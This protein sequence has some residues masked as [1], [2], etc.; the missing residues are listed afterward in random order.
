MIT[1]QAKA[2]LLDREK[3]HSLY[4][5]EDLTIKQIMSLL[6][7]SYDAVQRHLKMHSLTKIK[8]YSDD[9]IVSVYE[10]LKTVDAT[11]RR[12]G[13]P[14][15]YVK[16]LLLERGYDLSKKKKP[17]VP[18]ADKNLLCDLYLQKFYNIARI[19]EQLGENHEDV[20][21]SLDYYDIPKRKHGHGNIKEDALEKL[22][23]KKWLDYQYNHSKRSAISIANELGVY[24]T[25]PLKFLRLHGFNVRK[26]NFRSKEEDAILLALTE[27]GL[28]P[29]TN[30][31]LNGIEL[32]IYVPE[33]KLAIEVNGVYWHTEKHGRGKEYHL[34]K[35]IKAKEC[36]V[37]LLHYTDLEVHD[38]FD[39]IMS[40]ITSRL[41]MSKRVFARKCKVKVIS[42][43]DAKK[44]CED[45]HLHG[46]S[47]SSLSVGL[48]YDDILVMVTT[49]GKS[50]FDK[51][52]DWEIVRSCSLKGCVIVGGLSKTLSFFRNNNAGSIISYCDLRHGSGSS[53][54]AVGFI[55]T[56]VTSPGYVWVRGN[57]VRSRYK[58]QPKR[59]GGP[60]RETMQQLGFSRMWDCG[61]AVYSLK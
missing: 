45:N 18:V 55:E 46:Y 6:G 44:F 29:K 26:Y 35:T 24:E 23:D 13:K 11:F 22:S 59:I 31:K 9:E 43:K 21:K 51:S 17:F 54:S 40:M 37:R 32:D 36:G 3:M 56:K 57:D 16:N 42:N 58:C 50:R 60:E 41:G 52:H 25:T 20:S 5:H 47:S 33:K 2:I 12:V 10:E 38:K 53:Y 34:N 61:H 27:M 14:F 4:I 28:S 39:V 30:F 15:N 49:F 48:F 19:A 8:K 1:E 7:V